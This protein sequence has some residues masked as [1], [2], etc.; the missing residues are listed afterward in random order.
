MT[1]GQEVTCNSPRMPRSH[2][3]GSLSDVMSEAEE[4]EMR[5]RMAKMSKGR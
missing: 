4:E 1:S 5:V 3:K 2:S